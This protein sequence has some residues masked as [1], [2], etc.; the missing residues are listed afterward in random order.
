MDPA[1]RVVAA[2]ILIAGVAPPE[3][4]I[5]AVPLTLETPPPP[6]P[7]V[8]TYSLVAA[9]VALTGAARLVNVDPPMSTASSR[10]GVTREVS[11]MSVSSTNSEP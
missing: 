3:D 5:G 11:G 8:S 6:P 1:A 2:E 7:L 10:P 4:A 9:S